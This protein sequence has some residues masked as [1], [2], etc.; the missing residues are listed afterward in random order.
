MRVSLHAMT[1]S[2]GVELAVA[3]YPSAD[4]AGVAAIYV[5]GV[6]SSFTTTPLRE[7]ADL[8]AGDGIGGI[9]MNTRGHDWVSSNRPDRRWIGAAFERFEDCRLDLAA[10]RGWLREQGATRIAL[11]GHS[12]GALKVAYA[13]VFDP[14][15]EVVGVA[16]CSPPWIP[17]PE[18]WA[19]GA[20]PTQLARANALVTDGHPEHLLWEERPDGARVF[21]AA[22]F[23]DKYTPGAATG[24]RA[25][26]DRIAVPT[27]LLAGEAEP[28]I[29]RHIQELA[30]RLPPATLHQQIVIP[31][32]DH[33]YTGRREAVAAAL[34]RWLAAL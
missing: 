20:L 23:V 16:L 9:V 7:V 8:L 30:D 26:V 18:E 32:A 13:Q 3:A 15:V 28:P 12:L 25:Y 1:T 11:V 22:T 33:L 10:G 24:I 29:V 5:H 27:L 31:G 4:P 34:R 17:N 6:G 2:D 21:S 19:S 14:G